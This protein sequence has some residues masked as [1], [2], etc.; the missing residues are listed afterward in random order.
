VSS[1]VSWWSAPSSPLVT[2]GG[3]FVVSGGNQALTVLY[4]E[5]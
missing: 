5:A 1:S 3:L 2:A 4:L